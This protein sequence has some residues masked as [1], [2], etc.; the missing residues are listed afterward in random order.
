MNFV[1]RGRKENGPA[2]AEH[3]DEYVSIADGPFD[4]ADARLA[5]S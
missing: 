5:V 1:A 4:E 2:A 3:I